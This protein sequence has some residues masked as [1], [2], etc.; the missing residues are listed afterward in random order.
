MAVRRVR[1]GADF[2]PDPDIAPLPLR[3]KTDIVTRPRN[4]RF[5]PNSGHSLPRPACP[6]STRCTGR[7]GKGA[8]LQRPGWT[9]NNI[10]ST[11]FRSESL[12]KS[13]A[14]DDHE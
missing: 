9:G 14:G 3:V 7:G 12:T 2:G 5:T 11:R 10:A 1:Y 4:V 6:L 13:T 8:T